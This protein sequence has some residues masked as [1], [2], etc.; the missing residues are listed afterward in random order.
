MDVEIT[1][2]I[3]QEIREIL[4][5]PVQIA[6]LMDEEALQ[7]LQ[8]LLPEIIL[9]DQLSGSKTATQDAGKIASRMVLP[10]PSET[11]NSRHARYH[12]QIP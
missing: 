7:R 10:Q 6:G 3:V 5:T 1:K 2:V 4:P 12:L 9:A 11:L 8:S